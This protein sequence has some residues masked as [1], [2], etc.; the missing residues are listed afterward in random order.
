[1]DYKTKIE[2]ATRVAEELQ[3]NKT[4]EEVKAELKAQGVYDRDIINIMV[5]A[6]NIIGEKYKPEIR[7]YLVEGKEVHGAEAFGSL[8]DEVIETLVGEEKKALAL[9]E[10]KKMVK[11]LKEGHSA[12]EILNKVDSRFL[13]IDKAA[14]QLSKL[15]EVK[16]QNSGSGRMMSIGGGIGLIVLTGV[17]MLTTDRL[18]YVLPILGL[19]MIIKGF[20]TQEVSIED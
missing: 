19:G 15:Q 16:K 11:L 13:P 6:R 2:T 18:F 12:D 3:G 17:I 9:M 4:S 14:K 10:K 5:S 20:L 7:R 1:M 8:D